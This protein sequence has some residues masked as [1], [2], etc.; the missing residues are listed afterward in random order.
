ME[1]EDQIT[2][3]S[4]QGQRE[5]RETHGPQ[6]ACPVK[7]DIYEAEGSLVSNAGPKKGAITVHEEEKGEDDATS[8]MSRT[9]TQLEHPQMRASATALESEYPVATAATCTT[10]TATAT[11]D[12]ERTQLKDEKTN[13]VLTPRHPSNISLAIMINV[14]RGKSPITITTTIAA[15]KC[16]VWTEFRAAVVE[17]SS[18]AMGVNSLNLANVTFKLEEDGHAACMTIAPTKID[19]ETAFPSRTYEAWYHR[20]MRG[21]QSSYVV[22]VKM[23]VSTEEREDA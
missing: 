9:T 7:T 21:K 12:L 4:A 5:V 19:A 17:V 1:P 13:V 3:R 14:T 15:S 6:T 20:I 10:A 18:E 16:G 8:A 22:D 2:A 23:D 11:I